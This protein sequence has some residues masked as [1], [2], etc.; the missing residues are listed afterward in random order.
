MGIAARL[1]LRALFAEWMRGCS[2]AEATTAAPAVATVVAD[3]DR[4][5]PRPYLL[6]NNRGRHV[7]QRRGLNE[8]ELRVLQRR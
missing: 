2:R 7:G 4:R 3:D 6:R 8:F 1:T 5:S